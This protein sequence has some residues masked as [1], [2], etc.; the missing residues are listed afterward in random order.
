MM[1]AN[2]SYG[3][4]HTYMVDGLA[5]ALGVSS[6]DLQTRINNGETPYQ[7]L[8]SMG[9][10]A[11]EISTILTQAH[12]YALDKAVSAGTLTQAQADWMDQH[13]DQMWQNG[14][15]P[16]YAGCPGWNAQA[17]PAP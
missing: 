15:G 4:M 3:L 12:K 13:M 6:Q 8:Q 2:G 16:G 1:G 17:T 9:K 7:I 10:S 11:T 5:Q 14:F